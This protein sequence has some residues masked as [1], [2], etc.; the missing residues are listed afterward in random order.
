L[1]LLHFN[2]KLVGSEYQAI[3]YEIHDLLVTAPSFE[4]LV[5]AINAEL[6]SK[7]NQKIDVQLFYTFK[8]EVKT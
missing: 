1:R 7:H 2:I 8:H 5:V 6:D 4:E 3:C